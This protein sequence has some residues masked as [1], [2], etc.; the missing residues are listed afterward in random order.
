[1]LLS[2]SV[3]KRSLDTLI[4]ESGIVLAGAVSCILTF[5]KVKLCRQ[6]VTDSFRRQLVTEE[7]IQ[8][9]IPAATGEGVNEI[10]YNLAPVNIALDGDQSTAYQD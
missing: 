9:L 3:E 1:M 2:T 5:D 8:E 6:C 4:S 7:K 10:R